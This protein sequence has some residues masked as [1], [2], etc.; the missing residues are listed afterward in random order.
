MSEEEKKEIC[1]RVE[2]R[3]LIVNKPSATRTA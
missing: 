2:R 1:Q 3:G